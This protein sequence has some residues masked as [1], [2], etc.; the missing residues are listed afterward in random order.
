[1]KFNAVTL[2]A[3]IRLGPYE[4]IG[5]LGAGGMGQVWKARD[6]RLNRTVAI[7]VAKNEFTSRFERE[8]RA[9]AALNH[10]HIC[11]IYDVG[12]DYIVMELIEGSP[13]KG[14]IPTKRAIEYA[15]QILDAL[16]AAHKKGLTHRDLK[17]ANILG[18]SQGI[19]LLDF[20]LAKH[21][22]TVEGSDSTCTEDLTREGQIVGTL[23]YMSPE[24]LQGREADNRSDLFAFGAVLYEL[25]SGRRAFEGS[26][27]ASVIAAILEREPASIDVGPPLERVI[28]TCLAKDPE[29]RFQ[30]ALDLKRALDWA[31]DH[32]PAVRRRF[33][34]TWVAFAALAL[35]VSGGWVVSQLSRASA[36]GHAVRL[37][38]AP[39]DGGQ[40][41]LF[42]V[43][44]DGR[45][46]AFG[47][48][49]KGK[50]G[51]WLRPLDA[52]NARL[53]PGTDGA[54]SPFWSPDGTSIGYFAANKMWRISVAG[55]PPNAICDV[56]EGRGGAWASDGTIIFAPVQSS[57][58]RV[59]ASGGPSAELTRLHHERGEDAHYWPQLLPGGHILY[60]GRGRPED[61]GVYAASLSKPH[62]STRLLASDTNA[63]YAEGHLLWL[64]GS[65]LMA[66]PFE[67]D[68]LRLRG[69][70]S[71]VADAVF[72][73]PQMGFMFAAASPGVLGYTGVQPTAQ[74][75][76]LDQSGKAEATF[77]EAGNYTSFALSRDG[78]RVVASRASNSGAAD[79]WLVDAERNVSSRF[80]FEP[81]LNMYP[82]WSPNGQ[83]IVFRS[84]IPWNLYRK[85]ASGVETQERITQSTNSQWPD[86]WS[87]NGQFLLVE[88]FTQATRT[89]LWILSMTADG[90]PEPGV[91][92]RLYLRTPF[93]ERGARFS[94]EPNPLWVAYTSDESGRYEVY[95]QSFPEPK[96]KWQISMG[97]GGSPEWGP[98]GDELFY[99]GPGNKLMSV[100]LK[101]GAESVEPST[102]RELFSVAGPYRV[103]LDGKRFLVL[104]GSESGPPPLQLILNWP[105][106]L[107]KRTPPE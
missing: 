104:A 39:P 71:S 34:A 70:A 22:T 10:P 64:R 54:N 78:K 4:M 1:M 58:R 5:P 2:A 86:D 68:R 33:A 65:T 49:V 38:L 30:T 99:I 37:Q 62:E 82:I 100:K 87:R 15:G 61:T 72:R 106:L 36:G 103:A 13:L 66:Q 20:G 51:L 107:K 25:L 69:E 105:A 53:L 9:I 47:A 59:S 7:K 96:R 16:A 48:V 29:Q 56:V 23:Q 11:Q 94:P 17:P 44:P 3:G 98:A 52:M 89:D 76:W 24:Q 41:N 45:T 90:K 92:P 50:S 88:E 93:D 43:S 55:G 81:G 74:F 83:S 42:A 14:P 85:D 101:V 91:K 57:L 6:T 73:I 32:Q 8:A 80:T 18:T 12:P 40:F 75:T 95:I 46:L 27:A 97:G 28:R 21:T 60:W 63:L 35:G 31:S 67:A 102:P 77:G 79:L 84:G 26:S 19:K